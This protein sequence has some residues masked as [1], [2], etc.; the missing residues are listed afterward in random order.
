MAGGVIPSGTTGAA[1]AAGAATTSRQAETTPDLIA[2][3]VLTRKWRVPLIGLTLRCWSI[4]YRNRIRARVVPSTHE[5]PDGSS[6]R[7]RSASTIAA[8][9]SAKVFVGLHPST[10]LAFEASPTSN[11]G[12]AGRTK[13]GSVRT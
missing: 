4:T 13:A 5:Q 6:Y 3:E 7:A 9:I 8:T 12:S 10:S 2:R 11:D 1:S